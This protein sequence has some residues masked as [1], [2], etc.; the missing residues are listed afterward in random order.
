LTHILAIFLLLTHISPFWRTYES[1]DNYYADTGEW[2]PATWF[3]SAEHRKLVKSEIERIKKYR[4]KGDL[5]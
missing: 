4:E 1:N 2:H 3:L 5:L